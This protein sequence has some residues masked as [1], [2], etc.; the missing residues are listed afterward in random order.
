MSSIITSLQEGMNI[1]LFMLLAQ[2]LDL[3][4]SPIHVYCIVAKLVTLDA[5]VI[6][7]SLILN[8]HTLLKLLNASPVPVPL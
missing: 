3:V 7:P 2:K 6:Q 8:Y 4:F 5:V 1:T